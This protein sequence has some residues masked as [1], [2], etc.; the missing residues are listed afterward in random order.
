MTR[1]A[2]SQQTLLAFISLCL[3]AFS[4]RA[5]A[6]RQRPQAQ[7]RAQENR[8]KATVYFFTGGAGAVLSEIGQDIIEH[9]RHHHPQLELVGGP[10]DWSFNPRICNQIANDSNPGTVILLGHSHGAHAAVATAQCLAQKERMVDLLIT[11]DT[12]AWVQIPGNASIIPNNVRVNYNFFQRSA[13]AFLGRS[14]NRRADGSVRGIHNRML[15]V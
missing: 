9:I 4:L 12:I 8:P 15:W 6:Q 13:D 3:V 11:I 1:K 10:M 5:E 14:D 2:L 7:V